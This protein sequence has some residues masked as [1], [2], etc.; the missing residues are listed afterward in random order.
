VI[1]EARSFIAEAAGDPLLVDTDLV[2]QLE[3]TLT[4]Q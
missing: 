1:A 2:I 4:R 3:H